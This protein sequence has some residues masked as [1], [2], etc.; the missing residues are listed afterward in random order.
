MR[1]LSIVEHFL[2]LKSRLDFRQCG[3]VAS[4]V[5][6][7][8]AIIAN[9]ALPPIG[10]RMHSGNY[11]PIAAQIAENSPRHTLPLQL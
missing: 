9:C 10:Q 7:P 5:E 1:L 2:A 3:F 8:R 6:I 4:A 11:L